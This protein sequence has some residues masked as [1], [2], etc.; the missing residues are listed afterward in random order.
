MWFH[1]DEFYPSKQSLLIHFPPIRVSIPQTVFLRE[2]T[3]IRGPSMTTAE[4]FRLALRAVETLDGQPP[5]SWVTPFRAAAL[6]SAP[7]PQ[8][9]ANT[10]H[11]TFF[12]R[13]GLPR[14]SVECASFRDPVLLS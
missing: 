9:N 8:P 1:V 11:S 4:G 2:Y 13:S 14:D 5:P 10:P 3:A 12:C 7:E 6:V